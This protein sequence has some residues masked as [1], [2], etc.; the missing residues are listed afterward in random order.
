MML[1]KLYKIKSS[2]RSGGE[3][4]VTMQTDTA[5]NTNTSLPASIVIIELKYQRNAACTHVSAIKMNDK[6][7]IKC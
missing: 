7:K 3:A 6:N 2:F 1:N 5:N 4:S